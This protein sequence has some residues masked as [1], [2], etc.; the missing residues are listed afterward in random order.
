MMEYLRRAVAV[1]ALLGAGWFVY[2]KYEVTRPC[3]T[4]ITYSVG[5][6]DSRFNISR[7]DYTNDLKAAAELWNKAAGKTV[8]T[9]VASGGMPVNLVYDT[10]Q[11]HANFG[12]AISS[13]EATYAAEKA[14]LDAAEAKYEADRAA[15]DAKVSYW[16]A[17]GG[18]PAAEYTALTQMR[19]ALASE[20]A[21]L[22]V[23]IKAF[24]AE[25][26][27]HNKDVAA[28]N[29]SAGQIEEGEFDSRGAKA[30]INLYEFT[31]ETQLE[32]LAAHEFGHALGLDHVAG[33]SSIMYAYNAAS[34]LALS[35][36]DLA[37][38]K[39]LCNLP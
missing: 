12:Q 14:N 39:A 6:F 29:A 34:N 3:A 15:Y 17:R 30:F 22:E 4:T 16:N 11:Q 10:R 7:T 9:Y 36:E 19:A 32:R 35:S 31:N 20:Q 23:E 26:S 24:N 25:V 13:G 28:Y 33:K 5:V 37:A 1:V 27:A 2:H 18:A 8:L 21:A 38:F